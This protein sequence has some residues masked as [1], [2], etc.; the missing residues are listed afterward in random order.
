VNLKRGDV[1]IGAFSYQEVLPRL[2]VE[3]DRLIAEHCAGAGEQAT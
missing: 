1:K 2:R 3:L